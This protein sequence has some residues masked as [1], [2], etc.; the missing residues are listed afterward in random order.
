M[1]DGPYGT[2]TL[3]GEHAVLT[4]THRGLPERNALG[5]VPGTHAFLDRAEAHL[6]GAEPPNWSERYAEVAPAYRPGAERGVPART[7][8]A[9]H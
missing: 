4:F 5:F 3:E 2:V 8:P 9:G 6:H 7:L 1:T